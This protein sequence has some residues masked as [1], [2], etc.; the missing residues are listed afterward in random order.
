MRPLRYYPPA[1]VSLSTT[2]SM[3]LCFCCVISSRGIHFTSFSTLNLHLKCTV[4]NSKSIQIFLHFFNGPLLIFQDDLSNVF[5]IHVG[6]VHS[7]KR[8]F[9]TFRMRLINNWHFST[10]KTE[11]PLKQSSFPCSMILVRRL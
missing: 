7:L 1:Q 11:K 2:L 4:L 9:R 5:N 8:S 10:F 3:P 6:L